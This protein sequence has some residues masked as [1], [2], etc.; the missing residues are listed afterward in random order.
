MTSKLDWELLVGA[1]GRKAGRAGAN[2]RS[3][4]RPPY[5]NNKPYY[6]IAICTVFAAMPPAVTCS[7]TVPEPASDDGNST[8][9]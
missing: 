2:V 1:V 7:A 8:L 6:M 5:R 4:V 9:I 3:H